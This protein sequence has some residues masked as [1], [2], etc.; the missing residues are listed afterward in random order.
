MG[1]QQLQNIKLVLQLGLQTLQR[2][3]TSQS[4]AARL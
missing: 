1:M 3:Q 2:A 4:E